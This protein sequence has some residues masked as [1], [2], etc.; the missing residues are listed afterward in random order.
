MSVTSLTINMD[1]ELKHRFEAIADELGLGTDAAVTVFAKAMVRRQGLPFELSLKTP[2]E[3]EEDRFYSEPNISF[4][5][6]SREQVER[7][8][9]VAFDSI[10]ELELAA[11][12]MA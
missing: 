4:L 3:I 1:T 9:V 2:E 8:E 6:H 5:L 10:D 12:E 11:K 7:G